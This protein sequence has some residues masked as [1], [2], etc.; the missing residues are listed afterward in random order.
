[1]NVRWLANY[2]KSTNRLKT[3]RQESRVERTTIHLP[4]EKRKT[5]CG[6]KFGDRSL[7]CGEGRH[8]ACVSLRCKCVCGHGG[9]SATKK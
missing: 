4:G 8:S 6:L 1:M 2:I 7:A 9:I 5:N 3:G